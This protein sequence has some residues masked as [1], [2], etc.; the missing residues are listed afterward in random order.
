MESV[1]A[2]VERKW[3]EVNPV[4]ATRSAVINYV[5]GESTL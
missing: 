1:C 2:G 4:T 5:T 3:R